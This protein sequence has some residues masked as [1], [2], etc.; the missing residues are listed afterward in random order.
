MGNQHVGNITDY[1]FDFAK[2]NPDKPALLHPQRIT[3]SE[4]C[5][6]IDYYAAGFQ[7]N[8]ILKGTKTIVLIKP[9]VDLFAATYAL[10]RIGAV[11]VLIDPG[12]GNKNMSEALSQIKAEAFVG[13]PKAMLLNYIFPGYYK[14]VKIWISTHRCWFWHG[15]SLKHF[16]R[17]KDAKYFQGQVE[18]GET[19]AVFFTSGS[20]GPAKGVIY[21]SSMLDAQIQILKN[22]FNYSPDEIDLCTFPLIGLLIMCLGI[23][24]V[25]ADM[26]MTHPAK[27]KPYKLIQNIIHYECTHM[28]CSPMVLQKLARFGNENEIHLFTLKR[29][30]TAGAP[31]SADILKEFQKIIPKNSEIHTPYGATEALP[32]TDISHNELL[33]LYENSKN[34]FQGICIGYPLTD[35]DLQIIPISDTPIKFWVDAQKLKN[36]EVGE[37]VVS[38]PNVTQ[39]YM[40]NNN[41]NIKSKIFDSDIGKYWHRTGDLG[42]LDE[43]GR[44][45]FY[46]RKSQRVDLKDKTLFTIPV[47]SVFNQHYAVSRSALVGVKINFKTNPVICIELFQ[48]YKHKRKIKGELIEMA[49]KSEVSKDIKTILFYRKFPV[50][51]R[52]NV[53]I[54]RE[55]LAVRAQKKLQ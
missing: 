41:A 53:K 46:G 52:H 9:G 40:A 43:K 12:M 36:G 19:A 8:G 15:L 48:G 33:E 45:W 5:K 3:F 2:S 32:V 47:E 51:P 54:F 1:L 21:K 23:T 11:P 34:P 35:I 38:G 14:T 50:D 24:V 6:T 42:R 16:T 55:K 37:I 27:L 18:P 25:L 39:E 44:V 13:I 10:L 26:D 49:A 20:T 7:R 30:M 4:L 17:F 28:F 31:V 22:H 29:I